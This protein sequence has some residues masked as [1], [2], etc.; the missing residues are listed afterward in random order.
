MT[1]THNS[2]HSAQQ[3]PPTLNCA[4]CTRA[5]SSS[6]SKLDTWA[7]SNNTQ[8]QKP[9]HNN[10]AQGFITKCN[11]TGMHITITRRLAVC[12]RQ[13]KPTHSCC[14]QAQ[15]SAATERRY[16]PTLQQPIPFTART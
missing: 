3:P 10:L 15:A 14:C 8:S 12:S 7:C 4:S 16:Q 11:H 9:L 2:R 13:A 5:A 1:W 6:A